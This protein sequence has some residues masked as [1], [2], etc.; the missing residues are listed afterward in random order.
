MGEPDGSWT[1]RR[2]R[3][4][5]AAQR[6]LHATSP[7]LSTLLRRLGF[8]SPDVLWLSNSRFSH[9]L[10]RLVRA[11]VTACRISDDWE[12][13]GHVPP[14]LIALHDKMVDSVDLV[15]VTSQ[16]LKNKLAGRRAENWTLM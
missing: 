6:T 11:R 12:H 5:F 7:R 4:R 13:F 10:P 15:F 1:L 2:L 16:R 14:A 3:S 8:S 9:A